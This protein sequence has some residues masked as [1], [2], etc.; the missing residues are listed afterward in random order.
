MEYRR[1][2]GNDGSEG[3]TETSPDFVEISNHSHLGTVSSIAEIVS[4]S[5]EMTLSGRMPLEYGSDAG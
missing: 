4:S 3:E 2:D 5:L 1:P